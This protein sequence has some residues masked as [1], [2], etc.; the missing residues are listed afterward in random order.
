MHH[1]NLHWTMGLSDVSSKSSLFSMPPAVI[2]RW[3]FTCGIVNCPFKV[4]GLRF[5]P[6]HWEEYLSLLQMGVKSYD[7]HGEKANHPPA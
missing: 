1:G 2:F 4:L 3:V 6:F 5:F 7:E